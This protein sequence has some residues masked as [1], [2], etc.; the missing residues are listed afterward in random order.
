VLP[1]RLLILTCLGSFGCLSTVAEPP[2]AVYHNPLD[3]LDSGVPGLTPDAGPTPDGGP[4]GGPDATTGTVDSHSPQFVSAIYQVLV[5]GGPPRTLIYL[6]DVADLCL[7]AQDGGLGPS[8]IQLR[9]HLA[10]DAPGAY[11]VQTI[12]PP[13]GATAELDFQD[14]NGAYGF[15]SAESG[16]VQLDAVDPGNAQTTSGSYTLS[17]GDAGSLAGRFNADPCAANP[18]QAGY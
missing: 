2:S 4:P 18:P 1:R 7:L 15:A 9:L 12:L 6:A 14:Q 8:W 5:S 17:F 10:G 16:Q 3:I 13:S 11:A